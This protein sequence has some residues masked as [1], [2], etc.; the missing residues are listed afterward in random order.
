MTAAQFQ[1]GILG[2]T[3]LERTAIQSV[4]SLTRS[5]SRRYDV[6]PGEAMVRADI[7]LVDGDD[8]GAQRAW[9]GL[10]AARTTRPALLIA[11]DPSRFPA[12][13]YTLTR[14]HFAGR[15][16]RSL[17]EIAIR[18]FKSL[19]DLKL[20]DSGSAQA[21][22]MPEAH[23]DR[24]A[25]IAL[26]VDDSEVVRLQL[27]AFLELV[28]MR[29]ELA[30]D[31]EHGLLLARQHRYDLILLDVVLP[32]MDGYQACRALRSSDNA[33][34]TPVVMLTGRGS[35]FD[36]I[37]GVMAGCSRYLIKPIE[38]QALHAVVKEMVPALR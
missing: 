2:L 15:L 33:R 35:T 14:G 11:G 6:L 8:V 34:S 12:A 1:L 4:C 16:L 9:A 3:R 24:T 36:R 26:V 30:A 37:R 20:A 32:E 17:D 28:G 27:R 18:E 13:H 25:P 19:P 21:P 29:V 7:M 10:H 22:W 23:A 5:R 38:A 31:A